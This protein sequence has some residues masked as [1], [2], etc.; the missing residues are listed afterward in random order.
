M[1][2]GSM[3]GDSASPSVLPT[4]LPSV[5]PTSVPTSVPS[6]S[7]TAWRIGL[8]NSWSFVLGVVQL[9]VIFLVV[10]WVFFEGLRGSARNYC[11]KSRSGLTKARCEAFGRRGA[12]YFANFGERPR[13]LLGWATSSAMCPDEALIPLCGLDAYACCVFLRLCCRLALWATCL[14]LGTLL[15]LYYS[16]G[17]SKEA[18]VYDDD[19]ARQRAEFARLTLGSISTSALRESDALASWTAW[20]AVVDAWLLASLVYSNVRREYR[21]FR[22]A[23][24]EWLL[25]GDRQG[26]GGTRALSSGSLDSRSRRGPTWIQTSRP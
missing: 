15:P 26:P 6:L 23:R 17:R 2:V 16:I 4:P 24:L 10:L 12:R 13:H 25:R 1:V 21:K 14:S 22:D 11:Y 20:V 18:V 19:D 5:L 8:R 9:Y 3:M 7:P